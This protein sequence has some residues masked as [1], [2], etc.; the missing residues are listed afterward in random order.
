M[1]VN[2]GEL[3]VEIIP[4]LETN[5]CYLVRSPAH[6][7][8][9][10]IDPSEATPV[11]ERLAKDFLGYKLDKILLTHHHHDHVGGAE[12]LAKSFASGVYCSDYDLNRLPFATYGFM[13]ADPT[14]HDLVNDRI[15]SYKGTVAHHASDDF[16]FCGEK[17]EV[18]FIPGHTLGHI[19]YYFTKSRFLFCGDTLFS[20]GCGKLFEG[21]PEQMFTSLKKLARLPN[22]TKVYCGH[23]YTV[24]N[25]KF[26]LTIEPE[27]LDIKTY[28][29]AADELRRR[30]LP[31]IP[32]TIGVEKAVNPFMRASSIAELAHRR[33]LKDNFR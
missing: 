16:D 5:Y 7:R 23:E 19:A 29:S 18:L 4:L 27:S 26:A 12:E 2:S 10:I 33:Q 13:T 6:R 11:R 21:T 3:I 8:L 17:V 30:N 14:K 28:I 15:A 25:L 31:T 32:S 22:D 1:S 24:Q 9:L 20:A